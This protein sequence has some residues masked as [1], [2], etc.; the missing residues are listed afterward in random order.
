M[1]IFFYFSCVFKDPLSGDFDFSE[2]AHQN[3]NFFF[4]C[5]SNVLLCCIWIRTCMVP[6][7]FRNTDSDP[8]QYSV[9]HLAPQRDPVGNLMIFCTLFELSKK[10]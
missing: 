5:L 10:Q 2:R 9:N 7:A 3:M 6:V 8:G 1:V 4:S